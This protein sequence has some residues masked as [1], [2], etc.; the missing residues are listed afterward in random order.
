MVMIEDKLH[1]GHCYFINIVDRLINNGNKVIIF[2]G[3]ARPS[4][5]QE[6]A[7]VDDT[8]ERW[9]SCFFGEV[10]MYD[11]NEHN[12]IRDEDY[13][14][15]LEAFHNYFGKVE[16]K[17][18]DM[19]QYSKLTVRESLELWRK[20]KKIDRLSYKLIK[21]SLVLSTAESREI[22]EREIISMAYVMYTE[23][24][25]FS[26]VWFADFLTFWRYV[27]E[28][29]GVENGTNLVLIE[30]LRNSYVWDAVLFC[31]K[32]FNKETAYRLNKL[33]F[34]NV[35]DIYLKSYMKTKE[36]GVVFI[37]DFSYDSINNRNPIFM[38]TMLKM[39]Q[40]ETK[41]EFENLINS[42]KKRLAF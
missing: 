4:N 28:K 24:A 35:P 8:K 33:Y 23:P 29:I 25:W 7:I 42:Y 11:I 19:N 21:D 34:N 17:I 39:F 38:K 36:D 5:L 41:E 20:N 22:G 9:S 30:S 1:L 26:D 16:L 32:K 18:G 15:L 10:K 27:H 37:K 2:I 3:Q 13:I 6:V 14:K 31:L 40:V 12:K